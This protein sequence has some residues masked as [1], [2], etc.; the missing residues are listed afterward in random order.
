VDGEQVVVPKVGAAPAASSGG[1][2]APQ[3]GGKVNIN[4]AGVSDFDSLPGIG[5]VLA[6]KIVDYRQQHGPFRSIEDLMKVSGIGQAKFD[7]LKDLVTV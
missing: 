1:G 4:S 6:Q 3:P 2:A 5:P 7:S